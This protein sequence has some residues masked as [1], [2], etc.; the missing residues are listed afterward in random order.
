MG[1]IHNE[2]ECIKSLSK[3]AKV[4][5]RDFTITLSKQRITDGQVGI[6]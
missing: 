5:T 2:E 1:K 6:K 4:N 3:V